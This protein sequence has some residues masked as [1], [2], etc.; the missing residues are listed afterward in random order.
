MI[1]DRLNIDVS[2]LK[3]I[4]KKYSKVLEKIGIKTVAE[5]L[6]YFPR[7]FSDRT[8]TVT[9]QEATASNQVA[10]VKVV[11]TDHRAI[12]KKYKQFLKVLIYDGKF[13]GS[14][15]CFNRNFLA[16]KLIIGNYYYITGK[17]IYSYNE[18]QCST[19]ETEEA[20]DDYK[21]RI[22]PIYP[23]TEGL[24][25]NSLRLAIEDA[26]KKYRLEIEN[27]LPKIYIE[28]RSLIPKREALKNVH[29]PVD[30]KS[31]HQAKKTFIYEEFFFQRFFLLKRK[32]KA[33]KIKKTRPQI[34][35]SLKKDFLESLPFKLTD[36]QEI[37]LAE[38]EKDIFSSYV[39]S[40]LLQGDVG[41]GKTIVALLSMLSVVE[42]GFQCALMVPTEV[43]ATQHYR[44]IKKLCSSLW[45]D[46]A[47]LTGSLSKKERDNVL[48]GLK[49]GEIKIV[50]GTHALFSDDVIYKDLG[51]VVIDEQHRFGVEQRYQLLSKG[52]AVDLLLMT[53]TPIPR[54]LALSLYGDLELTIMR[55]TIKGRL[56]VK[57][58][59]I[60]DNEDRIKKMHQWIKDE[61]I[62]ED[63]RAIFVYA[64]IEDSEKSDNK[65]LYSEYE[66]LK[67]VYNEL[68]V[69]FIHSKISPL[70]KDKI[71]EDFRNGV[72]KVLTATTVV[73][74][75]I[76]VPQANII[77]IENAENYG[78]S[79]LHQLRGR[80]GRNNKQ[81]YMVLITKTDE[82]SEEGK[83]RLSVITKEHDG[84]KIAEED[85][86]LRGPG[87]FIGSR[88]SGLPDYKFADIRSDLQILEEATEDALDLY[89]NDSDL[90]NI[91]N[92]NTKASF[93]NRLKTFLNNYQ[94]RST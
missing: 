72:T 76:D 6:E 91:E 2:T 71:M 34:K 22:L 37:A 85:L 94:E 64:L 69:G 5:L 92:L 19:F 12:G 46:I 44:T 39:F 54:T 58:W 21:G 20:T 62:K 56:P 10:T 11:V 79:T 68:G 4:G 36:Y 89:K 81:G 74:V 63:G 55:G 82:L 60:D 78:L 53:A 47:L 13:Y 26:L 84:F 8:K 35:F 50:I 75:G 77:I 45:L 17:F 61:I 29:F 33:E 41:S 30:F 7:A 9:L 65:D 57:T 59:L 52:D 43:L 1:L 48:T 86:L 40:R 3:G 38:I 24:T 66:K 49:T 25:Q 73:E 70:E 51:F 28:K 16:N 83:Q 93:L 14:L 87:D 27:E 32:E 67:E 90:N 42:S 88:Q 31:F 18:I 80:V 15:L 23:L